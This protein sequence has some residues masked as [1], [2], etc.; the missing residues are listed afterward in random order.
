MKPSSSLTF[1][2]IPLFAYLVT[3]RLADKEVQVSEQAKVAMQGH[4]TTQADCLS[5]TY[6]NK[7]AVPTNLVTCNQG[8]CVC[9]QCFQLKNGTCQDHPGCWSYNRATLACDDKRKSQLTTFLLSLFL[10]YV[11]AANFYIGQLG[12]GGTQ[13]ALFLVGFVFVCAAAIPC[14]LIVCCA[15]ANQGGD[16]AVGAFVCG[17]FC[18][19][20]IIAIGSVLSTLAYLALTAWWIA[21]LVIFVQN[22]RLDGRGCPLNPTLNKATNGY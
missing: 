13:L 21:D 10:A 3:A 16:S 7:T 19:A 20:V 18:T 17:T 22:K 9:Q 15:S 2:F 12:L 8:S 11:G 4:C 1:I 14:C 6:R 5:K